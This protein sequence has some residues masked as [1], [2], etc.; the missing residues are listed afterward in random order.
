MKFFVTNFSVLA[1]FLMVA[2]ERQVSVKG[3]SSLYTKGRMQPFK[4]YAKSWIL[5][6]ARIKFP[7]PVLSQLLVYLI[8]GSFQ[9]NRK[10]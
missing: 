3:V 8:S 4:I 7:G 1:R 2:S 9:K 5:N 6:F 10:I